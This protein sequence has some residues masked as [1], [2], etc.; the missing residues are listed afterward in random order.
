SPQ[1]I[2]FGTEYRPADP[3]QFVIPIEVVAGVFFVLIALM[4]VGLGQLMGRRF[5]A[6]P[7]RV[8][9]Y[10]TDIAGSLAG[11]VAFAAVSYFQTSP[12]LWFGICVAIVLYL[13]PRPTLWQ[14]LCALV[15]LYVV[16]IS[17]YS[18][19]NDAS[20]RGCLSSALSV[21]TMGAPRTTR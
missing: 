8:A 7:N 6:I 16:T 1:Q 10:T 21:A 4:F 19:C 5:N 14:V 17:G 13:I 11:I 9:S 20:I 15:A 12:L 2:F 18:T 3:S